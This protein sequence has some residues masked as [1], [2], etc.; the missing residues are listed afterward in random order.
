MWVPSHS[1]GRFAKDGHFVTE[2]ICLYSNRQWVISHGWFV[3]VTNVIFP[4]TN[5]VLVPV[6]SN[7]IMIVINT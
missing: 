5:V 7:G 3:I 6:R 4:L 1:R 2:S